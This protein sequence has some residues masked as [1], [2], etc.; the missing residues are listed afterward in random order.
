MKV[1]TKLKI[2]QKFINTLKVLVLQLLG[3]LLNKLVLMKKSIH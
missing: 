3:Q 1:L 2:L